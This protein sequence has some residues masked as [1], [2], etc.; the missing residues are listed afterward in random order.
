MCMRWFNQLRREQGTGRRAV[1]GR[2]KRVVQVHSGRG[3]W[4]PRLRADE[5]KGEYW[6][7]GMGGDE[8]IKLDIW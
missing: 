8:A 2:G 1:T 7:L 5:W 6:G 4:C 3:W